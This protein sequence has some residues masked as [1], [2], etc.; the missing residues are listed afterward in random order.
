MEPEVQISHTASRRKNVILIIMAGFILLMLSATSV[1]VFLTLRNSSVYKGVHIGSQDVSGMSRQEL[2]QYLD[3][4]YQNVID[5]LEI[6]LKTEKTELKTSYPELGIHYDTDAAAQNAYSIGRKGNIFDRLYD[7]AQAGLKGVVLEMPLSFDESKLDSFVNKFYNMTFISVKEGA[8]YIMSSSVT[9]RSG[10]HGENID[11]VK[12]LDLVKTLISDCNGGILEPEVLITLPTK[13]S[14]DELHKQ[15]ISEPAD[16]SYKLENSVLTLIPH[17]IGRQIDKSLL[18]DII[19][20]LDKTENTERVLPVTFISPGITSEMAS[21][22]LFRD[23]LGTAN[24]YFSTSTENGRNRKFNMGLAVDKINNMILAPG[25]EFSFNQVVGPRD[26]EHGYKFAHVYIGGKIT[27]GIGGGICQVSTTMYNAV[28]EADLTVAE[29]RN[30]SFT[31]AYVPLGQDATAYY[32]GTDF[33]FINSTNWPMQ[34]LASIKGNHIY[35]TIKGTIEA[36]EKSVVISNKILKE[37]PIPVKY[38]DDPTLPVGTEKEI[39]EGLKGFV[40]ETYKT[41]KM[42]DKVVSETKLHTSTYKA[43]AQIILRGT[44]PVDPSNGT[45][46]AP[47]TDP[48]TDPVTTPPAQIDGSEVQDE[49]A[50]PTL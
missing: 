7:I 38:T 11:K 14:T 39:E 27:D 41:I 49:I 9:I 30:H 16:A 45:V 25:Q 13:F 20:E 29:R 24:T 42:G 5:A 4:N 15:L 31:V 28:L 1:F 19:V 3:T 40:V 43:Y 33:R 8:I 44:K 46:T 17:V 12:T 10:R 47:V 35:F 34:L 37:I 18:E 26:L 2:K 22:M 36:P 23:D 32:G 6:T 50:P 21:S 48:V